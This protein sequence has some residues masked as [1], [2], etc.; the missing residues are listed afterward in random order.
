MSFSSEIKLEITDDG[1]VD[2]E[3]GI[4]MERLLERKN[5]LIRP[6]MANLDYM[7]ITAAAARINRNIFLIVICSFYDLFFK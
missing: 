7:L 5:E 1:K 2:A 4:L 6:P 3:R